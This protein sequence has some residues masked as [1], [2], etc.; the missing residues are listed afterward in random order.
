MTKI[1]SKFYFP[2]K[3]FLPVICRL[4]DCSQAH[5]DV[6]SGLTFLICRIGTYHTIVSGI[7]N[8]MS[9]LSV[10]FLRQFRFLANYSI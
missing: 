3:L 8:F 7:T 9:K 1:C 2:W 6:T 10:L 4:V 5:C